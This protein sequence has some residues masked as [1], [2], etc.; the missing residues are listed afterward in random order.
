MLEKRWGVLEESA[1]RPRKRAP[2]K[3]NEH[4]PCKDCRSPM[5]TMQYEGSGTR[6]YWCADCGRKKGEWNP[7]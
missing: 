7:Q 3:K 2:V 1:N 5:Q 6:S 4:F